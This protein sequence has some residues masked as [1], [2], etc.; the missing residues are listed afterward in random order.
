MSRPTLPDIATRYRNAEVFNRVGLRAL[1]DS[2]VVQP[3]WIGESDTFWYENVVGGTSQYVLVDAAARTKSP[4]FDNGRLAQALKGVVDG[5]VDP[6][7]LGVSE[8]EPVD[9]GLR[10]T[11]KGQR[12]EL[13]LGTYT[14]TALGAVSPLE[15]LSPDRRWAVFRQ[16]HD[17]Y[18]RDTA[19][20]EVR[21]LTTD[22]EPGLGYGALPD[23]AVAQTEEKL[24]ITF[25]PL[26]VW[27]PDSSSFITHRLDQRQVG[28]MHLVRSTPADGGRPQLFSYHYACSGDP[29]ESLPTVEHLVADVATGE[30]TLAEGGPDV[31]AFVPPIVYGRVW[32]NADATAYYVILTNRD[33]S[34]VW[35]DEVD[36]ATGKVRKVLERSSDT[37]VLLAPEYGQHNVRTLASGEV[38]WWAQEGDW[39]HLYLYGADG[40]V[41][42]LTAGDWLVRKVVSVDEERRRV[43]FTAAGRLPGSD[44]YLQDLC[45]VSLDGGEITTITA[46]GLDHEPTS[47]LTGQYFVDTASRWD[48]PNVAV[49]R[50]RNGR[51]VMELETA[52]PTR[53]YAAGWAA[54]ERA[55]VKGADGVTDIYCA[56]YKPHDFDPEQKYAVLDE[57]YPGPH[58]NAA[59]LRFPL[60]GGVLPGTGEYPVFG[61]LGF[62]VVVIDG[63]GSGLRE[64][65]FQDLARQADGGLYV[66]D[67]AVAISQLASDRPWMDL[68]R[69][70]IMGH[71]AGG[72]ASAR[73]ILQRPDAFRV[74]VS[75]CGNHDNRVNHV[76]WAEKFYGNA[77]DFD[78]ASQANSSIADRLEG[79]LYLIHGEMDDN[80]VPHAT[81]RLVDALIAANKDFD[82]LV[83]PNAVHQGVLLNGY[84][85]RK[86]WDYLVEHLMGE[87]PPRDYRIADVPVPSI[88]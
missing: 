67:H 40:A 45:S 51:V 61:A 65:S 23:F 16:D 15:V 84:W 83:V 62:V 26:V 50:D 55:V 19:T 73:A 68:E 70:G 72:F 32:W 59:P 18:V 6:A 48:Q 47:S 53:L 39:G 87:A 43:L 76:G 11:A 34:R 13:D 57:I 74:A 17:L 86:R 24:G 77:D 75:S 52:D 46:D 88:L 78:F 14:V 4:A 81:M 5:E 35:L 7:A 25:P 85:V 54:P 29:V 60:S 1:V 20:D 49:G 31:V 36:A 3:V 79:R 56:V 37:Q 58:C 2:P 80:A 66:D 27:S 21:R 42:Q 22:G 8:L 28:L 12:V 10:L 64:K 69:V 44:P 9:G 33:D 82:M 30:I 63:R 71:S 38:L 41:T